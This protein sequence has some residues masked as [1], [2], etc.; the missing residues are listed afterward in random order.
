MCGSE[1]WALNRSD[2]KTE[3]AGMRFLWRVSAYIL[4]G[5]VPNTTIHNALQLC[6][7][8]E[9]IQSYTNKWHNHIL[10]MDSSRLTQYVKNN[11]QDGRRNVEGP[12]RSGRI[13]CEM[14]R[15]NKSLP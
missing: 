4:T 2:R 8:E 10:R 14:E 9:R 6:G 15:A 11:N 13:V 1:N 3:I 7:S 12:K 5:Y